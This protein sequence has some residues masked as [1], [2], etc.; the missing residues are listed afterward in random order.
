MRLDFAAT[1][2]RIEACADR[3][4]E[5]SF[6]NWPEGL[7]D[8]ALARPLASLWFTP[9]DLEAVLSHNPPYRRLRGWS[10]ER[11]IP[12]LPRTGAEAIDGD[13]SLF[14]KLGPCSWHERWG[15]GVGSQAALAA[16]G[17]GTALRNVT[18][19]MAVILHAFVTRGEGTY[20]HLFPFIDLAT[21]R[22]YRVLMRSGVAGLQHVKHH[23]RPGDAAGRQDADNRIIGTACRLAST[24]RLKDCV[25]DL[26]STGR[27]DD[28]RLIEIN[29]AV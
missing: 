24:Y 1:I 18:D 27:E 5:T 29:P 13:R 4:I 26:A 14:L 7:A 16:H 17:F 25:L 21:A 22:E 23:E 28:I 11:D 10:V 3:V 15:L 6:E 19:R 20:L 9:R 2:R 12:A 8:H